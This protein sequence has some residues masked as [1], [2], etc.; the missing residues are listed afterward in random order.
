MKKIRTKH[1]HREACAIH[2][3]DPHNEHAL[4]PNGV[5][6]RRRR[7][8]QRNDPWHGGSR[9]ARRKGITGWI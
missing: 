8:R 1:G 9:T 4:S 3:F 5:I 2:V 7:L 6:A